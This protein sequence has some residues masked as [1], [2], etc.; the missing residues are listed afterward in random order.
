[1]LCDIGKINQSPITYDFLANQCYAFKGAKLVW[2]KRD[3][4]QAIIIVYLSADQISQ[5]KSL[6]IFEEKNV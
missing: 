3:Y 6:L 2:L 4:H 1:M 5:H